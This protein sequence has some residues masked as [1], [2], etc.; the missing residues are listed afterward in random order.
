MRQRWERKNV[1]CRGRSALRR[2]SPPIIAGILLAFSAGRVSAQTTCVQAGRSAELGSQLPPG[3][4]AAIA[5]VESGR[6]DVQ[7]QRVIPWPWAIDVAGHPKF[8]ADKAEAVA[9]TRE[10][11]QAGQRNIDVGCYQ[12]SLLHH[13][14]A[15]PSLEQAFDP[16]ANAQYAAQFLTSLHSQVRRLVGGHSRI[17]FGRSGARD[18]ISQP[19]TCCLASSRDGGTGAA[20]PDVRALD[21]YLDTAS[22]W[23][24]SAGHRVVARAGGGCGAF[25]PRDHAGSLASRSF[26]SEPDRIRSVFKFC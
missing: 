15:F 3:L 16:A 17:S 24:R 14:A 13:P 2:M 8:F 5:R 23:H 20:A 10:L 11:L 25:A 12:I 19:R 22:N 26:A 7:H 6:W 9:A 1:C 4:L 18:S 21:A